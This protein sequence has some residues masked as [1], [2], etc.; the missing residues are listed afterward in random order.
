MSSTKITVTNS[1][2][3]TMYVAINKWLDQGQTAYF[4]I[5]SEGKD[6]WDRDDSR[7]FVMYV[8]ESLPSIDGPYYVLGGADVHFYSDGK[9]KGAVKIRE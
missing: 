2:E 3:K 7:G 9:V 4:P 8:K 6:T 1:T 5:P